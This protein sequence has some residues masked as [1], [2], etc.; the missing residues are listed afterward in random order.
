MRWQEAVKKSAY[1]QHQ[2]ED[3]SEKFPGD[4][5]LTVAAL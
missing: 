3:V 4:R 2:A 5:S 1:K